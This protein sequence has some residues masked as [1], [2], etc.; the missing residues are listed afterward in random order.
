MNMATA[1]TRD[2]G[3]ANLVEPWK[4]DSNSVPVIEFFES[5]NEAAEMGR[6]ST[7]DK[8]RLARLKLRGA[9][10]VFYTAQPQLRADG[11][12]YEEFRTAFVN[13]FQDKHTDQYNY[14]RVQNASQEKNESPEVFLDRLRKLC[15]RTLRSSVNPVEQ[16]IINQEANRRLLAAFI[17][18]LI[19]AVGKQ[20][21]MQMPDNID[22]A[23]NMAI[24][25][26]NAEREEK[27]L[28][29]EDR[30][31]N[32]RVFAVGGNRGGTPGNNYQ[33]YEGLRGKFQWS[34]RGAC[35]EIHLWFV[36]ATAS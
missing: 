16:A 22:K 19:G 20:V 18:G 23:L 7:K 3:V 14:A 35:C 30:G 15:Q 24:I 26:T 13:R 10:R 4:E 34:N 29:R 36:S 8:V 9:A 6:L 2:L 33:R 21:R 12:S 5:V 28:A 31:T 1:T 11:I 25:A 27:A 17:N 32:V